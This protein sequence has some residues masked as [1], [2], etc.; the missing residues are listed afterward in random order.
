MG[1]SPLLG[2]RI[3]EV[4]SGQF[5]FSASHNI[6]PRLGFMGQEQSRGRSLEIATVFST[7]NELDFHTFHKDDVRGDAAVYQCQ[8]T[9]EASMAPQNIELSIIDRFSTLVG[10][11]AYGREHPELFIVGKTQDGP[12][13][14]SVNTGEIKTGIYDDIPKVYFKSWRALAPNGEVLFEYKR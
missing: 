6:G 4:K 7:E 1:T 14:T 3:S 9:I 10:F 13:F 5:F 12:I 8:I 2:C 11:L